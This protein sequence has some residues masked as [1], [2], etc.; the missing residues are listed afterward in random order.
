MMATVYGKSIQNDRRPAYQT[1][2]N[3]YICWA[4]SQVANRLHPVPHP[5]PIFIGLSYGM[6]QVCLHVPQLCAV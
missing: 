5:L 2:A 4:K 6:S 1:K 3:R